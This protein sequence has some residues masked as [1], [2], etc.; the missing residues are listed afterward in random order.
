M[1]P[2]CCPHKAGRGE[3]YSDFRLALK[4][5]P[6]LFPVL[7]IAEHSWMPDGREAPGR[8]LAQVGSSVIENRA[9]W[10]PS[11]LQVQ[12]LPNQED[13]ACERRHFYGEVSGGTEGHSLDLLV[14]HV[15][16]C[17]DYSSLPPSPASKR[18]LMWRWRGGTC[19]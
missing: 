7:S 12:F 9:G 11:P 18:N 3:K 17:W 19:F 14:I 15:P 8:T 6:N 13:L 2:R 10:P 16:K 1:C 5:T 4:C